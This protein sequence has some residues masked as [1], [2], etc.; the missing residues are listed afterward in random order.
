[1]ARLQSAYLSGSRTFSSRQ[2]DTESLNVWNQKAIAL[3]RLD[4]ALSAQLLHRPRH[5]LAGRPDLV[6]KFLL[7]PIEL[8]LDPVSRGDSGAL[9]VPDKQHRQACGDVSKGE[10]LGD[11]DQMPKP[12]SQ[13]PDNGLCDVGLRSIQMFERRTRQKNECA[14]LDRHGGRW[15]VPAVEQGKLGD[16][17]AGPFDMEDLL[18]ACWIRPV[19]PYTAAFD[20]VQPATLLAGCEEHRAAGESASN[21][22]LSELNEGVALKL[23]EQRNPVEQG[24]QSII[25]R[26]VDRHTNQSSNRSRVT[27]VTQAR[28]SRDQIH[29][30]T[31]TKQIDPTLTVNE[32][33]ALYPQTIPVF[34]R[35][36][37]DTC[38]G[39]GVTVDAAARRDG[40]DADATWAALR[41][42]LESK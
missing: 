32:I 21:T 27:T 41:A 36:G 37:L 25:R 16:R 12:T 38:C 18:P 42:A 14:G 23:G 3:E 10:R 11:M 30:M 6:G 22:S 7:R 19:N 33:V 15:I 5:R 17:P 20:H 4:K 28:V 1:M 26:I 8:D 2:Q 35:F 34:N 40:V 39:G 13:R 24:D 31:T 9:G 29:C